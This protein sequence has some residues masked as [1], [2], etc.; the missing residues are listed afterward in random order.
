MNTL[1]R[2]HECSK[3]AIC[4]FAWK[5]W[6]SLYFRRT[7][8]HH[9]DLSQFLQSCQFFYVLQSLGTCF[10]NVKIQTKQSTTGKACKRENT[11]AQICHVTDTGNCLWSHYSL[12][13][14]YCTQKDTWKDRNKPRGGSFPVQYWRPFSEI[15]KKVIPPQVHNVSY[16]LFRNFVVPLS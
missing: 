7:L 9:F 10:C 3:E 1:R 8:L 13:Q 11:E 12:R 5:K 6:F 16:K 2:W 14:R 4:D 15:V